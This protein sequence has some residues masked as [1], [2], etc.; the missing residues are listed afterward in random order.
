MLAARQFASVGA[1]S[2][3]RQSLRSGSQPVL[4]ASTGSYW[5][6]LGFENCRGNP[7]HRQELG[8]EICQSGSGLICRVGAVVLISIPGREFTL[9]SFI[10]RTCFKGG[11]LM[12]PR[13]PVRDRGKL[14]MLG[15]SLSDTGIPQTPVALFR[16]RMCLCDPLKK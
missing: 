13:Q 5:C 4:R 1:T 10:A 9:S 16:S 15:A 14:F 11:I 8:H 7:T 2:C 3:S 6:Q 12:V